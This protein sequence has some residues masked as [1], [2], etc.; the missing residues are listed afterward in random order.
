MVT[1]VSKR[2]CGSISKG[3]AVQEEYLT[4]HERKRKQPLKVATQQ[5]SNDTQQARKNKCLNNTEMDAWNLA[6]SHV[7]HL[8]QECH[9][10]KFGIFELLV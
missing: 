10:S 7:A 1:E 3:Q 9:N 8:Q 2:A 6:I 5:T 4:L